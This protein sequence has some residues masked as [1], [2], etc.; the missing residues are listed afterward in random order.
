MLPGSLQSAVQQLSQ[1]RDAV[2]QAVQA[3]AQRAIHGESRSDAIS[4]DDFERLFAPTTTPPP[5]NPGMVQSS[6]S[7]RYGSWLVTRIS[8]VLHRRFVAPMMG[9]SS[10]A[11]VVEHG[12]V[13]PAAT[14]K[15][16]EGAE[17][18]A[19]TRVTVFCAAVEQGND[20]RRM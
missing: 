4:S 8:D 5:L 9:Q 3:R 19:E 15:G 2:V 14:R 18:R 12:P 7:E 17:R 13:D 16:F 11:S 10:W 20:S 6:D 1:Q